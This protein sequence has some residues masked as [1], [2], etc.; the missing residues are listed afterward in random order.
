MDTQ[1]TQGF[2]AGMVWRET[3]IIKLLEEWRNGL[4]SLH[5]LPNV[6]VSVKSIDG[7]IQMIKEEK[8]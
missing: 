8:K 2:K 1:Y 3:Q 6:V 5:D 4:L 7:I